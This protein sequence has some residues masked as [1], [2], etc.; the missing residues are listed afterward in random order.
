MLY[1]SDAVPPTLE[2]SVTGT[3]LQPFSVFFG[4]ELGPADVSQ[5]TASPG[6]QPAA[7]GPTICP[8]HG[9]APGLQPVHEVPVA[10]PGPSAPW[11]ST[12]GTPSLPKPRA[13]SSASQG[14]VVSTGFEERAKSIVDGAVPPLTAPPPKGAVSLPHNCFWPSP[15]PILPRPVSTSMWS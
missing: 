15:D 7:T 5:V 12:A 14:C 2:M 4:L 13:T 9:W 6:S 8:S 10:V 3:P 11:K 1:A